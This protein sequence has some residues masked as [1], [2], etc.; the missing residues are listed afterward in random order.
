LLQAGTATTKVVSNAGPVT[1]KVMATDANATDTLS[2]DWSATSSLLADTDNVAADATRV[3]NPATLSGTQKVVVKVTD[4]AGASV[5]VELDFVVVATAPVLSST[6]D[7][8]G[9]GVNDLAEGAGD[10]NGNAIPD[11]LE[12]ARP[13]NVIQQTS[14]NQNSYLIECD[15]GVLCSL[16]SAALKGSSGGAQIL[17]IDIG[18]SGLVADKDFTPVGG[19]FDFAVKNLAV[20]GHS[21]RVVIPQVTPIPAKAVYRKFQNGQWISFVEN[22]NNS[23]HS[24]AGTSGYCPPPGASNWQPGLVQGNFCV[25]VTL[26][27]GGPNDA[28]RSVNAAIADPGVVS[29]PKLVEP[30]VVEPPVNPPVEPPEV[31]V[32]G[33]KAKG[34]GGAMDEMW[35]L[36]LSGLLLMKRSSKKIAILITALL[37]SFNSSASSS[38]KNATHDVTQH[39]LRADIFQ[40]KAAQSQFDFQTALAQKGYRFALNRYDDKRVGAQLSYG[41]HW[42]NA[43]Y[44]EIGYLDLG[45]VEVDIDVA[46]TQIT[47]PFVQD[48]N[49]Q[50]P[51]TANGVTLAHIYNPVLSGNWN[52]SAEL[53]AFIWR[54]E[55]TLSTEQTFKKDGVDPLLGL[56]IEY[57][58]CKE[59]GLGL[60]LRRVQ[61]EKQ[62]ITLLGASVRWYF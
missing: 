46:S 21:V 39:Y 62:A 54:Q 61:L 47:E 52:V 12:T 1:A 30:P 2:Y 4:S 9:D 34:S 3:F 13:T 7:S 43:F 28:D 16:G 6:A 58:V 29:E 35:L 37:A 57:K 53:G 60:S 10:S 24:T 45:D 26:Q 25:Q 11:Y 27:D 49:V 36:L 48:L 51:V 20:P 44:S 42:G 15:P 32:T 59:A 33:L 5:N 17:N 40:V 50:Y 41:Y 23:L 22:A 55:Y 18:G 14:V 31:T 19:V 38:T 8:D 56:R